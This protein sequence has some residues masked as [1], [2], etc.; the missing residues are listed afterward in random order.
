MAFGYV[1]QTEAHTLTGGAGNDIFVFSSE[2]CA[3]DSGDADATADIIKDYTEGDIICLDA[4]GANTDN[5]AGAS[6]AGT[7]NATTDVSVSAG[8]KVTFAAADDTLAKKLVAVVA[9]DTEIAAREILFFE[10][11]G[12][13]Y[14]HGAG[15]VATIATDDSLIVL[16]GVTVTGMTTLTE[17]TTSSGD[18]TI[19]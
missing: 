10:D 14:I 2:T 9:D 19:A 7:T 1:A 18:F 15:D 4:T 3:L 8:G 6:A 11:C 5:V 17:S 13:T 12:N 16:E